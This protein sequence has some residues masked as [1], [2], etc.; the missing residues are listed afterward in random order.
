MNGEM[1]M[2]ASAVR[3]LYAAGYQAPEAPSATTY[4]AASNGGPIRSFACYLAAGTMG[5]LTPQAVECLYAK[6][7]SIAPI[8]YSIKGGQDDAAYDGEVER[9]PAEN[10]A[11]IRE[12]L[13]PTML[14][15][16]SLFGVSRQA[17]YDWRQGS[18]PVPRT[19]QRLAQLARVADVFAETGLSVDAKTLRRKVAGGGTLLDAVS[20]DSDAELVAQRLVG[21][22]KREALQRERLQMQLASRML[23]PTNHSDYGAPALS[24]DV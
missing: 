17:V 14:E 1:T 19:T 23:A 18:Q 9:S 20:S 15:L 3:S 16:A 12:V 5:M 6:A 2:T 13:K 24:D 4:S 22:L 21:T 11:R 10:L 8:H 7:T